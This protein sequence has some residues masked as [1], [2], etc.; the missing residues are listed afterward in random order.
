MEPL[1]LFSIQSDRRALIEQLRAWNLDV[2]LAGTDDHWRR[3][4]VRLDFGRPLALTFLFDP[5]Y[6]AEPNWSHQL[7]G[8]QNYLR[9]FPDTL[10]KADVIAFI[11]RLKASYGTLWEPDR[12][13]DADEDQRIS[14][15]CALA[16]VLDCVLFFPSGLYDHSGRPLLTSDGEYSPEAELP[17]YPKG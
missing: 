15:V 2:N 17:P 11:P 3:A 10:R 12:M 14:L 4:S 9:A 7:R 6:C 8:M 16:K 5:D 13:A 1:N